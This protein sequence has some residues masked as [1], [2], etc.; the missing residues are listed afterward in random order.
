M[1]LKPI[2]IYKLF[3]KYKIVIKKRVQVNNNSNSF[4][5]PNLVMSS[6]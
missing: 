2:K 4:T 5:L 6:K 1:Y 3:Q